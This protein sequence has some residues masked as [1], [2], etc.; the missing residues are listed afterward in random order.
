MTK[1]IPR[2]IRLNVLAVD[3]EGGGL[4][5]T[6]HTHTQAHD[7]YKNIRFQWATFCQWYVI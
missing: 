2:L 1:E 4:N 6:H 7:L 5:P 3:M